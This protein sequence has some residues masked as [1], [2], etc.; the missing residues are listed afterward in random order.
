MIIEV[1]QYDTT[2]VC[3]EVTI[4][5]VAMILEI[6][7]IKCTEARDEGLCWLVITINLFSDNVRIF[8]QCNI[9]IQFLFQK[10]LLLDSLLHF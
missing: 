1:W 8:S 4:T 5:C 3:D 2:S 6:Q 7:V 10:F 9:I